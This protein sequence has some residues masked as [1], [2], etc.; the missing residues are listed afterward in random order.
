MHIQLSAML[1]AAVL[2]VG[3]GETAPPAPPAAQRN[4]LAVTAPPALATQLK[5]GPVPTVEVRETLR[6]PGRVE[7]DEQR[8][9][10]V[11][12]S[13]TGRINEID[14]MVGQ[15]VT[16]GQL[17]ASLTSTE[18]SSTQLDYLKSYS[19]KLLAERAAQR[20]KQLVEADVIGRAELQRRQSE[21][22]QAE[23][24]VSAA[25]DQ[26]LVLG[27]TPQGVQKLSSTRKVNSI[28]TVVSSING[29][30]IERR[31][32]QGQVVQPADTMF[33]IADLSSVWLVADV[34]EQR[35]ELIRVG[36]TVEAEIAALPGRRIQGRLSFVS[37][38]VNPETRTIKARMDLANAEREYK[39]AM[40]AT[41]LIKS[42]PKKERAVPVTA[43]V[44]EENKEFVYVRTAPDQFIL[45]Q[46]SL[47]SEHDGYHVL[48][49]GVSEGETIVLDGAFQL[50]VERQR[51]LTQ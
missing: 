24:D 10:R 34:P 22:V 8:V 9:A 17:L 20:A 32:T 4:P 43:V 26:L 7:V 12:A 36:E 40:L 42:K 21:L 18:L 48:Q 51:Q 25:R 6:V 35:A 28:S 44:R 15:D 49:S 2:T 45:R 50:N 14:V 47:G 27:M 11:G 41:V 37:A 5:L 46:V 23:A 13:V 3:C 31:V 38:T 1:L 29:T 19:Q 39:P 16:R 33:V 30:V